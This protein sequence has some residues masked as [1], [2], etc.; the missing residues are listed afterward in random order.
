MTRRAIDLEP[1]ADDLAASHAHCIVAQHPVLD[2][3][4][5]EVGT[6]WRVVWPVAGLDAGW[7]WRYGTAA[8]APG[9]RPVYRAREYRKGKCV[10]DSL[11]EDGAS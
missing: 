7:G 8:Y 2:D 3:D 1:A 4:G 6:A 5:Y 11:S 9:Q 10:R